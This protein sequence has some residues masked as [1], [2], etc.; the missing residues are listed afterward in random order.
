MKTSIYMLRL[1]KTVAINNLKDTASKASEAMK[2]S[3]YMLRLKA[4]IATTNLKD[5]ALKSI[6]ANANM[7]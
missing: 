1:K 3:I 7:K 4:V 2:T 5:I 6:S